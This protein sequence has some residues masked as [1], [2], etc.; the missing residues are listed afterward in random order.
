[1][2]LRYSL[3]KKEANEN[4]ITHKNLSMFIDMRVCACFEI[5]LDIKVCVCVRACSCVFMCV[6]AFVF[7]CMRLYVCVYIG[8][9]F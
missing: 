2:A 6:Y 4:R 8:D 5:T 9:F 1:V 7:M 3:L